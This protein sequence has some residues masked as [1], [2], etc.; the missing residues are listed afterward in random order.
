MTRT[1]M[2]LIGAMIA[3]IGTS[4]LMTIS[5]YANQ[6]LP[7]A[8]TDLTHLGNIVSY[9]YLV[10]VLFAIGRLVFRRDVSLKGGVVILSLSAAA[11]LLMLMAHGLGLHGE[12]RLYSAV[13]LLHL[14][15][16]GVATALASRDPAHIVVRSAQHVAILAIFGFGATLAYGIFTPTDVSAIE[17]ADAGVILGAAVWSHNRPSPTLRMRILKAHAL[18]RSRIVDTLVCTGN[19]A[20]GELPEAEIERQELL[21]LGLDSNAIVVEARS[22]STLDQVLFLRDS[23]VP[24]GIDSFIIVSDHFHLRRALEMCAF[25]GIA[26]KGAASESPSNWA[27]LSWYRLR[28]SAALILYWM[29]GV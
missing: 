11:L 1:R 4:A 26:A 9:L 8:F 3:Q 2:L 21:R 7:V 13:A 15:V 29:F 6:R 28:D 20:P 22:I 10:L 16:L 17:H 27:L 18:Y 14:V 5:R 25:N 23:L 19:S 12:E 24:R